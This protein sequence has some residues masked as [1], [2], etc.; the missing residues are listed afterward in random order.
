MG[1]TTIGAALLDR[2]AITIA[3]E[4]VLAI[5]FLVTA[6]FLSKQKIK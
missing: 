4:Y 5:V 6:G 1:I 2:P 3:I